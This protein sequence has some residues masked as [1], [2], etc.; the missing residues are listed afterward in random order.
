MEFSEK[1]TIDLTE[2][3]MKLRRMDGVDRIA[4]GGGVKGPMAMGLMECTDVWMEVVRTDG[5]V[6]A[7]GEKG[8][9]LF[10]GLG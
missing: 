7:V 1:K 10:V 5:W 6:R 4:G 2:G 8:P 9:V 3:R